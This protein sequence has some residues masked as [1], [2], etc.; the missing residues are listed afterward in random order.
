LNNRR[1]GIAE[2]T[3]KKYPGVTYELSPPMVS[4]PMMIDFVAKHIES[5][6]A[7]PRHK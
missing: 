2:Q 4:D 3:L 7:E 6:L 5:A 1:A